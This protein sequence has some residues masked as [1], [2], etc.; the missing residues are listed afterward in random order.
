MNY[1]ST[2]TVYL[3]TCS[4]LFHPEYLAVL[5]QHRQKRDHMFVSFCRLALLCDLDRVGFGI[6]IIP[7]LFSFWMA[8][9]VASGLNY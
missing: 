3:L 2:D 7:R 6:I 8:A 9:A 5:V 4:I 1:V